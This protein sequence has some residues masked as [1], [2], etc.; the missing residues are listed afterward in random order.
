MRMSN[1]RQALRSQWARTR[2]PKLV[3]EWLAFMESEYGIVAVAYT[4][5]DYDYPAMIWVQT[6]DPDTEGFPIL[7]TFPHTN[8]PRLTI[9][10]DAN[11]GMPDAD[12]ATI[13]YRNENWDFANWSLRT[14]EVPA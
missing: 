6:A 13:I 3:A 8:H 2:D 10:V 14:Q 1:M 9:A 5:E 11:D 4:A 7:I 12:C